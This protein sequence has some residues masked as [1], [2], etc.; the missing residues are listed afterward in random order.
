VV[1][2]ADHEDVVAAADRVG[3]G[4]DR[5][6]DTVRGVA[7]GLV[8]AGAVEA[9][10]GGS[11]P[12]VRILVFDRSLAVGR[13]PSMQM[14]SALDGMVVLWVGVGASGDQGKVGEHARGG[15]VSGVVGA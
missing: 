4:G 12:S 5:F 3:E 7:L 10:I 2:L 13:V 14:Y 6:E 8:G 11:A 9:Q 1:D 15:L